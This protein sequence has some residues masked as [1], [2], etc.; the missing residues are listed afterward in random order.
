[1]GLLWHRHSRGR[2]SAHNLLTT[3]RRTSGLTV[4]C[5]QLRQ[6]A[7]SRAFCCSTSRRQPRRRFAAATPGGVTGF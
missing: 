4:R 7:A 6:H 1:M 5:R 2:A 3:L